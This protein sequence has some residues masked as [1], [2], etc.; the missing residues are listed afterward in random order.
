MSE[1]VLMASDGKVLGFVFG[2]GWGL[3]GEVLFLICFFFNRVFFMVSFRAKSVFPESEDS[4]IF[5]MTYPFLRAPTF[6]FCEDLIKGK[7]GK[8]LM[9]KAS[10][11]ECRVH[12]LKE[13]MCMSDV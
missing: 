7:V 8:N 2:G 4:N 6:S 10:S 13:G 9:I 3:S 11:S 5:K 12:S 1:L